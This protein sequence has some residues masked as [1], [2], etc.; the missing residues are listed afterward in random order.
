MQLWK[1]IMLSYTL[2]CVYTPQL[3]H[4]TQQLQTTA[5]VT[6]RDE[7]TNQQINLLDPGT[8]ISNLYKWTWS[9]LIDQLI[10]CS[11]AQ[12]HLKNRYDK[13]T[14][15]TI[16]DDLLRSLYQKDVVTREQKIKM[17]ELK[18]R[19]R[20]E[21]LLD[22]IIMSS[23]ESNHSRKYINLLNVM[24]SSDDDLVNTE[25][26]DLISLLVWILTS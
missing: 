1:D 10:N 11:A 24:K 5:A 26:S 7:V 2:Y 12:R 23:L 4:V 3:H 14:H 9:Q 18:E 22:H 16:G 17:G 6:T 8:Y 25:A 19:N 21:Y 15:L 20:M 13:L